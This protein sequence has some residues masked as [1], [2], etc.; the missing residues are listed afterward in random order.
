MYYDSSYFMEFI[1]SYPPKMRSMIMIVLSCEAFMIM[2]KDE[3]DDYQ[4][5]KKWFIENLAI[6]ISSIIRE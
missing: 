1:N 5:D 2:C 4:E 3:D 6:I